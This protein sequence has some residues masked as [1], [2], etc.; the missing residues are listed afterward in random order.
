MG[1]AERS[2]YVFRQNHTVSLKINIYPPGVHV[3]FSQAMATAR[4]AF[5]SLVPV[6]HRDDAHTTGGSRCTTRAQIDSPQNAT[7]N[8]QKHFFPKINW[9]LGATLFTFAAKRSRT[10]RIPASRMLLGLFRFACLLFIWHINWLHAR[11]YDIIYILHRAIAC[12]HA[13]ARSN[14]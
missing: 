7:R 1:V 8:Y 11:V 3:F 2:V 6:V 5:C 10:T 14:M 4:W 13:I 9:C 12:L